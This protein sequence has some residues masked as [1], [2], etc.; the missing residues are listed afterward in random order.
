MLTEAV[1]GAGSLGLQGLGAYFG[2]KAAKQQMALMQ[3]ALD[4]QRE[5]EARNRAYQQKIDTRTYGDLSPYRDLG[6]EQT[7]A[8]GTLL[9]DKNPS[10][11]I[12]PGYEFRRDAGMKTVLGNAAGTGMVQSGDTLRALTQYGQDMG[13]QEYKN[14]F[15]RW[16]QEGQFRQG[17]SGMGEQ[18]AIS[19]GQ[20][21]NMGSGI[22]A[23]SGN[24]AAQNISQT[25]AA[26][27]AGGA[28][29]TWGNFL[30][31]LGGIGTNLLAR[32]MATGGANIFEG[33]TPQ[34]PSNVRIG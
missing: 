16:L 10:D 12:D 25:S 29:R 21:A 15:D 28:S 2:A 24:Q 30:S 20:L 22:I 19:G 34:S 8:L 32:K 4:Y 13:S 6:T 1:M 18:A 27:D 9:R 17:L 26:S 33:N 23:N 11:Y 3:K 5:V 31:G 7:N 14:A